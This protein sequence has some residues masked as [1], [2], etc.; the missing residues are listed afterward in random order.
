MD[1]DQLE[2]KA[3]ASRREYHRQKDAER[4]AE[5]IAERWREALYEGLSAEAAAYGNAL[6]IIVK[7]HDLPH[8][9]RWQYKYI[10]DHKHDDPKPWEEPADDPA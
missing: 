4:L 5:K 7:H 6:R 2:A 1:A 9:D 3:Q 8:Y 10:V